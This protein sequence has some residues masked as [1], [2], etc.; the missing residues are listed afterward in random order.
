[1]TSPAGREIRVFLSSTFQD[2]DKERNYLIKEVFPKIRSSCHARHVGFT[3]IDL[4]WGVTEEE[5]KS[6]ATVEICLKEIDRCRDFPPFFIGFLGERYGWIPSDED[7]NAYRIEHKTSVYAKHI[8]QAVYRGISVTELEMD[9]AVLGGEAVGL[10]GSHALFLLRA[11]SLTS[12]LSV[13]AG[14]S[15]V[16]SDNPEAVM[17]SYFDNAGSKLQTLKDRIRCSPFIGIDGYTSV[18]QFGKAVE[19]Y[20]LTHLDLLFPKDNIPS[21]FERQAAAHAAFRYQR[22]QNFLPRTDV[23]NSLLNALDKR[24]DQPLLGPVLLSGG[25]GHGKSALMAD[26]ARYIESERPEWLVIDHYFGA[27]D[28]NN[29]ESWVKRILQ[30]LHPHI[31]HFVGDV[32]ENSRDQK[33]ALSTWIAMACRC[34][35]LK[36]DQPLGSTRLVLILDAL[37]QIDDGGKKLALLAP[38]VLGTNSILVASATEGTLATN[39]ARHYESVSIPPLTFDMKDKLI[40][41]TLERYCKK[42]PTEL[43]SQLALA[44]QSDSPLFL[45]LALEV[46]RLYAKHESL[47]ELT[48]NILKTKDAQTLFLAR[49]LYDETDNLTAAFMAL[50][51]ASRSGLSEFELS[52]LL[53]FWAY[54][55][56]NGTEHPRLPQIQLSRLLINFGPFLVN[57][58]GRWALMHSIFREAALDHFGEE[59]V[60]EHL[61]W[62][63]KSGYGKDWKLDIFDARASTEALHQITQLAKTRCANQAGARVQL[64]NDLGMLWVSVHVQGESESSAAVILDA[65]TELSDE[66]KSTLADRWDREIEAFD[67]EAAGLNGKA[68]CSFSCWMREI[69]FDRYRI[70]RRLLECLLNHQEAVLLKTDFRIAETCTELGR[71]CSAMADYARVRVLFERAL[72]GHEAAQGP[73]HP[74]TAKAIVLNDLAT[75]LRDT[76]DA[77]DFITARGLYERALAICEA[78]LGPNHPDTAMSLNNLTAYLCAK[79]DASDF[80]KAR[81]LY[82]RALVVCESALDQDDPRIATCLN[83]LATYLCETG[84]VEDFIAARALFERALAVSEAAV[85]PDHPSIATCLNNLA[86]YLR[87]TGGTKD[88]IAARAL[89]DRALVVSEAAVGPDHPDTAICLNNLA[90][91]L[92]ETRDAGDFATA[93][94]LYERALAVCEGAL[95]QK[96]PNTAAYMNNLANFLSDT[97]DAE[98]FIAARGLYERA[99]AVRESAL[100]SNHPDTATTLNNLANFLSDTGDPEDFITAR[101][102]YERALFVRET[103]LGQRRVETAISLNDLA[104]YLR[105]TGDAEDFAAARHLYERALAAREAALGLDHP[106]TSI[107]LNNLAA[108]LRATGNTDDFAAARGLYVRALSVCEAALG[109]KHP[110]TAAVMNNLAEYL[111]TTGNAADLSTARGLI[112]ALAG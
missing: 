34:K 4:R 66:E 71:T 63:F 79:G 75:Y 27:D 77:E 109:Q 12:H 105:T 60:R 19:A 8:Q 6:G 73:D 98:D 104:H 13:S 5:S 39:A 84:H 89:F 49:F 25:S 15:E 92:S 65:L 111:S 106:D 68:I 81:G 58:E 51:A 10:P 53:A 47:G 21:Q 85:G 29:L 64:V 36:S 14:F 40:R 93:R 95:G 33:E 59:L 26:L 7:I 44:S 30:S 107:S 23:R 91:I 16:G 37:D 57:R 74:D 82:Q 41:V 52:E 100:G 9:L 61:Y 96:H 28:F 48:D 80:S 32:P 69:A 17:S 62:H 70:T 83:N 67:T 102:L 110:S 35:E 50:L 101:G 38:S 56:S 103:A 54:P 86:D 72:T 1:M 31:A 55:N 90:N 108:Y 43:T 45:A 22:L 99:L 11:E 94:S 78:D 3:E 112:G 46:L 97:G 18:E 87:N 42:L 20:L 88:F 2:M 76:G 24:I